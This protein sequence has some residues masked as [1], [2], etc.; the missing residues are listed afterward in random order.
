MSNYSWSIQAG[1]LITAG[2]GTN[3]VT[4]N[5]V[6]AGKKALRVNYSNAAGCYAT[7]TTIDSIN[8]IAAPTPSISGAASVCD[9]ASS[10]YTT[11]LGMNNYTWNVSGGTITSGAG[12]YQITVNW[13]TVGNNTIS[14]NYENASGCSA[15][16]PATKSVNVLNPPLPTISGLANTCQNTTTTY[17]TESGMS[18]YNWTVT[19][20]TITAGAGT[21]QITVNWATTGSKTITVNYKNAGGCQAVTATTYNVTVNAIPSN[22]TITGSLTACAGSTGN[23]YT[24]ESS[25]SNYT[26]T[27]QSGGIIT[28]GLG[29]NQVTVNWN[30]AGKREIRVTYSNA[31]GCYVSSAAF[32]SVTVN[33]IT[34]PAI[35]GSTTACVGA[36]N[37]TYTTQA[38]MNNYDW[39]AEPEH[40]R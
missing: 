17:T 24:T 40:I 32:D 36:T 37:I 33:S 10:T 23:T 9:G 16:S 30:T 13:T 18:S 12:T 22:P 27:I 34:T 29:T 14:V 31:A 5:W 15:A 11:Q 1:G 6:V 3:S 38:G 20:G 7:N 39:L 19:G 35:T 2:L 25:M 4:V 28:S 8:V 26:W 21:Y